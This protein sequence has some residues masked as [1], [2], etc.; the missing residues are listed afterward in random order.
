[1]GR[2][3]IQTSAMLV[4]A[5][6]LVQLH[7]QS[8]SPELVDRGR[9][10]FS[11]SCSFCHGLEATGGAE[12]PNLMRSSL[13]RHDSGGDLITQVIL[14][15]R[16]G[17]GMPPIALNADQ[18]KSVVTFLHARLQ[19]SDLASPKAP[20][21]AFDLKRPLT[22]NSDAGKTYFNGAGKCSACHSVTGDL[23]HIATK[24]GPAE[25]Q[26]RFLYPE[27]DEPVNVIVSLP[28][29]TRIRGK[30]VDKDHF[31]VG[32]HDQDGWYHS[33]PLDQV[34]VQ[35]QDPLAPH[36]ELLGKYIN[37]DIHNL[38]AYLETLK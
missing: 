7:A 5:F 30:L 18:I 13:V 10:Q 6:G 11:Q 1:M 12:G 31:Y 33:W 24:Y 4:L 32:I 8:A 34:T 23:A 25:L 21:E 27:S 14:N 35:I 29:G 19:K 15:G 26:A 20:G 9:L 3:S 28:S 38:F 2:L 17:K 16:P 37:A 22:G 36:I